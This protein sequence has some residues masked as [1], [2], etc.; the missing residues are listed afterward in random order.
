MSPRQP[1]LLLLPGLACD[2]RLFGGQLSALTERHRVHVSDVQTRCPDLPEM[3][4]A[5]LA[6]RAGRHILVGCSMGGMLAFEI[7]RQAPDRVQAVALLGSSAR[8]DTPE[9]IALRSQACELFAAGRMAEVLRANLLFAFHPNNQGRQALLADYLAMIERAG[10]AQLIRQNRAVM[11]RPDSRA[12]L[13]HIRCPV[14]VVCG[15]ADGLTPPEHSREIAAG[16]SRA[17]LHIVAGA[18]HMLTIEQ[19]AAV[20]ALLLD[21]L[22]RLPASSP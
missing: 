12:L 3:A 22:Q 11:A 16:A 18:G 4:A 8:A 20:T 19:P 14:L 10:A 15:E 9:L 1:S 6:E 7:L 13:P 17:E 2:E 5:L 21:W